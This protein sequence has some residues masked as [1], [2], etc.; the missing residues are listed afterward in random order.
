MSFAWGF[1]V[2]LFMGV[3]F[4]VMLMAVLVASRAADADADEADAYLRRIAHTCN[5]RCA[6]RFERHF[7]EYGRRIA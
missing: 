4:G 7:D 2:G 3:T 6:P 5:D 1:A